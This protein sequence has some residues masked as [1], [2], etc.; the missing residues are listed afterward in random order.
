LPNDTCQNAP[1]LAA[2]VDAWP[3]LPEAHKAAIL[4]IVRAPRP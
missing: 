3:D 2:V 4:A 1:D